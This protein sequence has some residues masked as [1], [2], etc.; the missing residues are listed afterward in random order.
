MIGRRLSLA[1]MVAGVC[2]LAVSAGA[3]SKPRNTQTETPPTLSAKTLLPA[4]IL[5]GP[6]YSVDNTVR[7]DGYMNIYTMHT[8]K[9]D[10]RVDGTALLYTRIHEME[11]ATAMDNVNKG[12]EIGK[13]VGMAGVN[14][15]KGVFNLL[16]NPGDT[17]SGVGRSFTRAEEASREKRPSDDTGAVGDLLGYNKNL[18]EY[19][20]AYGVDPYSKNPVMQESLKRLAGAGFFGSFTASAAIPG[21]T[22]LT[23]MGDNATPQSP[24][25]VSTP[26]QDLFTAN[27]ERLKSMGVTSDV[28]DLFVENPHFS[29]IEQTRLVLALDR[30][31]GVGDRPLFINQCILTD[32][33]D[34]GRFRTRMAELYANCNTK[35]DKLGRFVKV[36]KYLAA[37]TASGDLLVAYPLDYLAWTPAIAGIARTFGDTAAALKVKSKEFLVSGE[38]SPLSA[39]MLAAAGWKV[40][41]LR[42]GLR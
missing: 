30:L 34:L 28:A 6:N 24:V 1:A 22:V 21:G 23:R 17:L 32:S 12:A 8:K 20:K 10:L 26:P 37:V 7:N 29:P 18:R 40:V 11:A 33:D 15:V 41:Q 19:A 5:S 42:E 14:A 36:G 39:K 9:G 38:V 25:D 16:T 27:R 13:S 4:K 35:G 3:A 31:T 2:L